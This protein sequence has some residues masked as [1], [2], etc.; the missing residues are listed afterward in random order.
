PR[1]HDGIYS[2]YPGRSE[3]P[4]R[5]A[6]RIRYDR[7]LPEPRPAGGPQRTPYHADRRGHG[8]SPFPETLTGRRPYG[9]RARPEPY[10]GIRVTATR[11]C[12][13][14]KVSIKLVPSP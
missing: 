9:P 8:R 4:F 5:H 14:S 10:G 2:D 7:P 1:F 6:S 12:T 3:R 11:Y 13:C